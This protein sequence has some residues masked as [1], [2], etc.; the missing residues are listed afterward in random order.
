MPDAG[1]PGRYRL[2]TRRAAL[3][4]GG[5]V[6]L[7]GALGG[8]MYY[9]QVVEAAKYQTLAEANRINVR[10]LAPHRGRILDRFGVPL[11]LNQ[12]NYR[13][14]LVA[15]QAGD[16]EQTLDAIADLIPVSDS[17][18]HRVLRDV[19]QRHGFVPVVVRD[20]ITW[21]ELSRV[22]VN[23]P[24]LPGVN[25]AVGL[26]RAYPFGERASHAVGYVAKPSEQDL[27][28]D[29]VLELPDARIGKS[30]V[31]KSED[32]ALRGSAGTSQVEV[33]ALGRVVR[34][35]GRDD[36]QTGSDVVMT[37]DMA[38][39]DFAQRRIAS[40][41]AA[42]CVVLDAI[43]GDVL[44]MASSPSYDANDFVGGIKQEVWDQLNA[45]PHGPLY[46]KVIQGVYP[47]G[48][49]FK[50]CVAMA[51]LEDSVITPDFE[52]TCTGSVKL[53]DVE[54]HCWWKDGHGTLDLHGGIKNSC[55]IYFYEIA[56]RAGVDRIARMARRLGFG[57]PTGIDIPGE[58]R[59][60]IPTREWKQATYGVPWQNGET[61]NIG[62]GQ[63]YVA[64]TPL[65]LVTQTARLVTNREVVA[66]LV[67]RAGMIAPNQPF[68]PDAGAD[69]FAP[70]G[71]Q[72]KN[73][74]QVLRGMDAV[75]NEPGGTAY[76]ARITEDGMAMGGK[77]G[78]AQVRH[79]TQAERD[80][81]LRKPDQVPW[82][83][84]DHA[85]FIAFAPVQAPRYVAA[86]V[87]EH[88]IGG[89]KYAAPIARDV[90]R[91]CQKRDPA[92]RFP[93]EP[94]IVAAA[95]LPAPPPSVP[96]PAPQ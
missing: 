33:N 74:A 54:F 55:D 6:A 79:I 60:L 92:R 44:V 24:E 27:D 36:G 35:V 61:L 40:E 4:A 80:H 59:G 83:E 53:G 37:L 75:C 72:Q 65:Q 47:P 41:E 25:V 93:P 62:I 96:P 81:G 19:R 5:Q 16:I 12:Q 68:D 45:D 46:N 38:L 8:R 86:V 66:R 82:K 63:G 10:L 22:E 56:R 95:D 28:G 85:V 52:V 71:F 21:E 89:S 91:E 11:A 3:L 58:R 15:D 26:T 29:P 34:E 94:A 42:C 32:E 23:S 90:L 70:L 73:L 2:L 50:P 20:N 7:F 69:D 18:R 57:A 76:G 48:S 51:A 39:Q 9:L 88:G 77:S 13:I 49:T 87:V 78:T 1:T 17:D 43:T 64:T 14:E 31:E 84:R 30:G 67:R